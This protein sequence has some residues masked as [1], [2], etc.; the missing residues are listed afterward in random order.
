M[1]KYSL[2]TLQSDAK[3]VCTSK[4]HEYTCHRVSLNKKVNN[5]TSLRPTEKTLVSFLKDIIM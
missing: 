1:H 3:Y 2:Y 4:L 5:T